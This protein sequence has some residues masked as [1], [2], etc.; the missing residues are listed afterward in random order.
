MYKDDIID[1]IREHYPTN[2]TNFISE[3][4]NIS[5]HHVRSIAKR[6]NIVK[7]DKYKQQLK[8]QLVENRKKWYKASIPNFTP[9]YLQEQIILGSLLGDGYISK[10]AQR[11]V[12]Y[13]YQEHFGDSQREYRLWKLSKLEN[14]NF[15]ISGNYL[16]SISHPYF[17]RLHPILYTNGRKSLTT[18]YLS[19]CN[20][21]IFLSTL[22]LDDGSLT[23]SYSYNKN[24]HTVYC[25][26]SIILYTLNLTGEE[27]SRLATYLNHIFNVHFVV[28]G[29]PDG[30]RSLLKINKE[31]E[32]NNFLNIIKPYV[33]DIPSMKYKICLNENINL[34]TNNI[35]DKFGKDVNVKISSSNRRKIYSKNEI[36]TLI[37]LK[38]SGYTDEAIANQIGRTYWSVVYKISRLRKDGLL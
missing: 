27:N 3:E 24:T 4:L 10:G 38:K 32:V 29:H 12:N 36:N 5:V 16:R 34:K 13:Y 22:Y 23:I 2:S 17:T 31:W 1:F 18:N 6:N 33:E 28:S 15:T 11:S 7:C 21:P 37:K 8:N 19:K 20:H 35:K 26:P 25:H 14:L 9:T 30:H